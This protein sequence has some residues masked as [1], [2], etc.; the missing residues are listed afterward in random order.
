MKKFTIEIEIDQPRERVIELFDNPD[1]LGY[2]QPGFVSFEHESG[3]AGQPGAKSRLVYRHGSREFEMIETVTCRNLPDEFSGTF[4]V[5][6]TLT[7]RARNFFKEAGPDKTKW[8]SE[9]EA[10][11]HSL[12]MKIMGLLMPNCSRNE[13]E[14]FM[15]NFKAFAETGADV[16]KKQ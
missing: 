14:N 11:S 10:E 3:E 8:I 4:H 6:G 15:Q 12:L 2:W 16:R 1:N 9:N 13:T 7:V 5:P